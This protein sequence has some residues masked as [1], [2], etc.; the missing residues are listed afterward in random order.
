MSVKLP[1]YLYSKFLTSIEARSRIIPY[2][3]NTLTRSISTVK[4]VTEQWILLQLAMASKAKKKQ[5]VMYIEKHLKELDLKVMEAFVI[6]EVE[7]VEQYL[8]IQQN[9]FSGTT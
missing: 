8:F 5:E 7:T 2:K 4:Y 1:L 9:N 3:E 6:K